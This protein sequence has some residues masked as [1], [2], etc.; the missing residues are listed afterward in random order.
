VKRREVKRLM[1]RMI[2]VERAKSAPAS[3]RETDAARRTTLA[4]IGVICRRPPESLQS[5]QSLRGELGFDSLMSLE[6]LVS[7]EAQLGGGVDSER[8]ASCLTVQDVTDLVRES[9]RA[10][11]AAPEASGKIERGDPA[12]VAVPPALRD[13]AM[14]WLGRAQHSFY[15]SLM[16]TRVTGRAFI[17]ANANVLVIA[18]HASHLDM[19]LVKYA[20]GPYGKDMVSL[21]A[22]DYFF[23]SGRYRKAYFQNFTNLM[24]LSRTGSLRQS[25]RQAGEQLEQGRVVLL[26]PE[27]TRSVSGEL[28]ELKPLAAH[29]ALHH[30]VDV[31]PM[32]L[33]GTHAALPKGASGI[34]SRNLSV[35]IGPPLALSEMQRLTEGLSNVE[36]T[37]VVTHL[38]RRSLEEL[39]RG[40]SL[41]TKV[42]DVARVRAW[43]QAGAE[44]GS[45]SSVFSELEGRFVR[46]SVSSP[47]SYY[48][49]LGSERW[50]VRVNRDS[51][52]VQPG[53]AVEVADCVLKTSP[54]M[55]RRIVRDAYSPSPSEFMSGQ[56]KSNNIQL[57]MTFQK[58]F[59]L[60][61]SAGGE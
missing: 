53:K 5:G 59:Q 15:G 31:L 41:D 4:A 50:T 16:S 58:A 48:F 32:W 46:G 40:R 55:F 36:R 6:L 33:G 7:L 49:S 26:F 38:M 13:A 27:G 35:R 56:V 60:V 37:R 21:A 51:C 28:Q 29:L 43:A 45:L 25:L 22:Q 20:L 2:E 47:L 14:H 18:N 42:L 8:L 34:R 9:S 12:P 3:S 23:E 57:L 30:G 1:E 61:P 17:P 19:G 10:R 24:P 54:S 39:S 11:P 52:W 44:P